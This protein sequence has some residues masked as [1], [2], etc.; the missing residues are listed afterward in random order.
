VDLKMLIQ[1]P[2]PTLSRFAVEG[3]I[4]IVRSCRVPSTAKRERVRVRVC[5][6]VFAQHSR[7]D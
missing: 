3:A 7:Y 1:T 2:T 6:S 4:E 5:G